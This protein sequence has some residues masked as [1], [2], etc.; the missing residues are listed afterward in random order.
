MSLCSFLEVDIKRGVYFR[1]K[2]V[3]NDLKH[4][5]KTERNTQSLKTKDKC[6]TRIFISI[7]YLTTLRL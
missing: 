7:M 3:P 2:R 4:H 1:K 5:Y 6:I